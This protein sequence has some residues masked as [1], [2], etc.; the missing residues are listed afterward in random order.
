MLRSVVFTL[1]FSA[2]FL[3]NIEITSCLVPIKATVNR[4]LLGALF[5]G[6]MFFIIKGLMPFNFTRFMLQ[7]IAYFIGIYVFLG[8][9]LKKSIQILIATAILS[10]VSEWAIISFLRGTQIG[11]EQLL[12]ID[13]FY[14]LTL[15][16]NIALMSAIA[17]ILKIFV[18]QKN[19]ESLRKNPQI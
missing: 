16:L 4:K 8:Q 2:T 10:A 6:T 11:L 15:C 7:E 3:P 13:S 5:M 14:I 17:C 1:L 18:K 12:Q 19:I 9:G